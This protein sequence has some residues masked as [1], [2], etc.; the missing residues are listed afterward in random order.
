MTRM[1]GLALLVAEPAVH[2]DQARSAV[3]SR[4][5]QIT[6]GVFSKARLPASGRLEIETDAR[7]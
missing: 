7:S 4:I 6:R 1:P 2:D 5:V 3:A